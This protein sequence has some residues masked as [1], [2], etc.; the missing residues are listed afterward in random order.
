MTQILIKYLSREKLS[1]DNVVTVGNYQFFIKLDSKNR[2]YRVKFFPLNIDRLAPYIGKVLEETI[3][4]NIETVIHKME[5]SHD[6]DKTCFEISEARFLVREALTLAGHP[7]KYHHINKDQFICRCSK[8]DLSQFREEFDKAKGSLLSLRK[9]TKAGLFC[10]GC[11]PQL[12]KYSQLLQ[13]SK[14]FYEGKTVEEIYDIV[15]DSFS[16]FKEYTGLDVNNLVIKLEKI[17]LP[18]LQISFTHFEGEQKKLINT[19]E[20]YLYSKLNF[21]IGIDY[22]FH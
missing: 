20:N 1:D 5:L 22:S 19:F 21:M 15:T 14:I 18:K 12:E 17:E 6:L 11:T 9:T 3:D 4:L 10:G 7:G 13:N 16:G 8:M 2:I